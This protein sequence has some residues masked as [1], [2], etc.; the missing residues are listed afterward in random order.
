MEIVKNIHN[1]RG[2]GHLD[3][4]ENPLKLDN[5]SICYIYPDEMI[6]I[7]HLPVN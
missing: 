4:L 3:G 2:M 7:Y 6:A 5:N 1:D